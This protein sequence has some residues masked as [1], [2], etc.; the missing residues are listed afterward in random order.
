M[1]LLS[2][3]KFSP[4]DTATIHAV[5]N[6]A[7]LLI[8]LASGYS[9]LLSLTHGPISNPSFNLFY[10]PYE[11]I[12]LSMCL[13]PLPAAALSKPEQLIQRMTTVHST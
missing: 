2:K 6:Y 7:Q 3:F 13:S 5:L 9:D 1:D 12:V 10:A 4:E 11:L 8:Q